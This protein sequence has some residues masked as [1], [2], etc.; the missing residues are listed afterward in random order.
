M[1]PHIVDILRQGLSVVLDFPANTVA[2]RQWLRSLI[3]QSGVHHEL[4]LLDVP[5]DVCKQRL[6][7]RNAA[8]EHPFQVSKE[9]FELFTRYY[10][11]P[12]S[13]EGFNVIVRS[14]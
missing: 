10:V 11:P 6:R 8:G 2:Q 12:A 4:H 14:V 9:D 7:E 13:D 3:V 5:D 1:M